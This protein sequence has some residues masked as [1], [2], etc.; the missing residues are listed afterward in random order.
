MK[1]RR[2]YSLIEFLF[3][4]AIATILMGIALISVHDSKESERS[5][6]VYMSMEFAIKATQSNFSNH[7]TYNNIADNSSYVDLDNDGYSDTLLGDYKFKIL[8]DLIKIK[9]ILKTCSNGESGIILTGANPKITN[10]KNLIYDSCLSPNI[11]KE[12]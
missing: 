6:E 12:Y 8:N 4:S 7:F 1:K 10:Y 5:K 9:A 11:N 2:G 3:A